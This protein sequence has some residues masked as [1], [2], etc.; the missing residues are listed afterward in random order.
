LIAADRCLI[1][2]D[3]DAFARDALLDLIDALE[4]IRADHNDN[5]TVEGVI[6]NQFQARAKLPQTAVDELKAA[7]I[8]VLAP[9]LSSSVKM[10]ES[11]A[12]RT[13]LIYLE[14][15]HRLSQEFV[16]LYNSL[17]SAGA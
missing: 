2:F 1:P 12:S 16:S 11:H 15:R 4:E 8:H 17:N 5:L 10:K 6:I 14:P 7:G 9:Y 13:P 3:C